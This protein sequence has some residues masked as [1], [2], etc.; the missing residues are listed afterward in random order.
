MKNAKEIIYIVGTLC[1]ACVLLLQALV[2]EDS[3][4]RTVH[5]ALALLL[6]RPFQWEASR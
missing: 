6:L 2:T 4:T 1:I 5:I 3:N